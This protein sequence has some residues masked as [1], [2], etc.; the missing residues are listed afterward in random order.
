MIIFLYSITRM[1]FAMEKQ[2]QS[3]EVLIVVHTLFYMN[4][5]LYKVNRP[6]KLASSCIT[7]VYKNQHAT[8]ERIFFAYPA[9]H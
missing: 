2:C 3:C 6:V 5:V 4:F 7:F 9:R 8:D 1:A